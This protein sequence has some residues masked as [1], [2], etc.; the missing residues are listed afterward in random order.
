MHFA[1][2]YCALIRAEWNAEAT[3]ASDA[4]ST[5]VPQCHSDVLYWP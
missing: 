2:T 3:A 5:Q 1:R 4:I